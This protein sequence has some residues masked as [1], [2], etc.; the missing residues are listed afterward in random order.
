MPLGSFNLP[1]TDP[2]LRT[3]LRA[4]YNVTS[5]VSKHALAEAR[6]FFGC[7]CGATPSC[8]CSAC[9]LCARVR[10]GS[11]CRA[12]AR[13]ARCRAT[14]GRCDV[15]HGTRPEPVGLARRSTLAGV[16]LENDQSNDGN[17]WE[18]RVLRDE[19][20]TAQP[21]GLRPLPAGHAAQAPL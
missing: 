12:L 21:A 11:S 1:T 7:G 17:H 8:P 14:L 2:I 6:R 3:S 13:H 19:I 16:P 18:M 10:I 15:Q 20:M 4:G 5:V 9:A